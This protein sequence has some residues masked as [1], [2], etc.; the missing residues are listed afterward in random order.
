VIDALA[1]EPQF[2]DH[3]APVWRALPAEVRGSFR[4]DP[5]LVERA[6]LRGV[7][8]E[9]LE[10][11]RNSPAYPAPRFD[12]PRCL[13]ASY[14]DVKVGRRLGYGPFAF[15]EHGAG[16]S[17]TGDRTYP[18][19]SYAGG[20]DREDNTLVMVPNE[21]CAARWL[22][23]YP[24]VRVEVVGCPRLDDLPRRSAPDW[25]PEPTVAVSFHWNA[26]QSPESRSAWGDFHPALADLAKAYRVIGHGHPK[27]DWPERMARYYRRLNIP[28]VREFDDVCRQADIYVC[29]NSST[30]WEF[31]ST[32]RPVVLMN[33]RSYR[34]NIHHGLRFWDE[35]GVGVNVD[36]PEDL[37]AAVAEGLSDAPVR[38]VA[39]EASV[40][41]VYQPRTNGAAYAA[42]AILDWLGVRRE[43]V[44]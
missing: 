36:R 25:H 38:Q 18:N 29:D 37:V 13:V 9:P 7:D 24:E 20:P 27:G 40:S 3:L 28:F 35:A 30:I 23:A 12:G 1:Y 43:A 19:G 41:R 11:P 17:Y 26:S 31:A 33:A 21:Q 8:A 2:L 6:R 10:R 14:G 22:A 34:R 42:T 32:G 44:A 16:Q 5:D 4:C 15:I 39:R